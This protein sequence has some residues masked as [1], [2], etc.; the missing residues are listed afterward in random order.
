MLTTVDPDLL[1]LAGLVIVMVVLF[2]TERVP[3]DV[4]AMGVLLVLMLAGMFPRR[5]LLADFRHR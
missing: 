5:R 1:G 2:V 4:T 3:V